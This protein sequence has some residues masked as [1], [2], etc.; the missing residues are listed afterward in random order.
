[1]AKNGQIR[2]GP[3]IL[4][5]DHNIITD[6][7][8]MR[9][10]E[11]RAAKMLQY[12]YE[13]RGRVISRDELL[14]QVWSKTALTDH[15]I[16]VV[17]ASLR[18][19]LDDDAANPQYLSTV[20]KRGYC[21]LEAAQEEPAPNHT[22]QA[23]ATL[24]SL[25]RLTVQFSSV[26][27]AL[28]IFITASILF[29]RPEAATSEPQT[30]GHKIVLR[31]LV[32]PAPVDQGYAQ[33]IKDLLMMELSRYGDV[34]ISSD[35]ETAVPDFLEVSGAVNT[36]T[37]N[38]LH[39]SLSRND[40]HGI[41]ESSEIAAPG[42]LNVSAMVRNSVADLMAGKKAVTVPSKGAFSAPILL[43][44]AR[45]FWGFHRDDRNR[46]A[47]RIVKQVLE[48]DPLNGDAHALLAEFYA[49]LPGASWGLDGIDTLVL[50]EQHIQRA[51]ELGTDSKFIWRAKARLFSERDHDDARAI[52]YYQKAL[53]ADPD[54]HWTWRSIAVALAKSGEYEKAL[55]AHDRAIALSLEP[56]GAEWEKM[57]TLYFAQQFNE[58]LSLYQKL[59]LIDGRTGVRTALIHYMAGDHVGAYGQWQVYFDTRGMTNV[60]DIFRTADTNSSPES[61]YRTVAD[62]IIF[63]K[64]DGVSPYAL[65]YILLA[66][67]KPSEATRVIERAY[68]QMVQ[69]EDPRYS[70]A[71]ALMKI[72]PFFEKH[73]LS[74]SI[75]A[76]LSAVSI[77]TQGSSS[78]RS[79]SVPSNV[80]TTMP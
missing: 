79:S 51:A 6:G 62:E 2:I 67:G 5:P 40:S 30:L 25:P 21:L 68:R 15:A 73:A 74:T 47:Y 72:D 12:L 70:R 77:T 80:S 59:K 8:H 65:S 26:A 1:M 55:E 76:I 17:V 10:L 61:V 52:E 56:S 32:T 14:Q 35:T 50:A 23:V 45:Y 20:R 49:A 43:D 18:Q 44:R 53:D 46:I 24:W 57:T 22:G 63:A 54:D 3:W 69:N 16:S 60:A 33:V 28:A 38:A 13:H 37:G 4:K 29:G 19:A 75:E 42:I 11:P 39:L 58:A 36:D 7:R 71:A 41:R 78:S 48:E 31:P 27:A 66:A 34:T 64:P 9:K